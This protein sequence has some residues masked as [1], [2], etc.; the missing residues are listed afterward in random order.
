MEHHPFI[1]ARR[2]RTRPLKLKVVNNKIDVK[3]LGGRGNVYQYTKTG[4]RKD[5]G[6]E[7]YRSGWEADVARILTTFGIKFQFEPTVFYFPIQRGTKSYLPD[8]YLPETDEYIEI[9]G[10]FDNKSKVKLKRFKKYHPQ[11]F[12]KLH[13][14][15]SKYAKKALVTC[16]ELGVPDVLFFEDLKKHYQWIQN[17]ESNK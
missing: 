4:V 6:K 15:I 12:N 10:W 3:A 17:W 14:I 11:E 8:F 1:E 2:K 5:L 7:V 16:Q 9:K 13:V